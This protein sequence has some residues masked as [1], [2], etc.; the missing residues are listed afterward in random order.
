ME[1]KR[2]CTLVR[3]LLPQYDAG[4]CSDEVRTEIDGHLKECG[5]CDRAYADV[6]ASAKELEIERF[7][8][9][10]KKRKILG[11]ISLGLAAV[12]AVG[13]GF[14]LYKAFYRKTVYTSADTVGFFIQTGRDEGQT[15]RVEYKIVLESHP[16]N[17]GRS[18]ESFEMTVFSEDGEILLELDPAGDK[19]F[20]PSVFEVQDGFFL[21]V[22]VRPFESNYIDQKY[23][24][25]FYAENDLTGFLLSSP[26][27]YLLC[28][29]GADITE[30]A[31]QIRE[32]DDRFSASGWNITEDDWNGELLLDDH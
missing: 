22:S 28:C 17:P 11:G 9:K 20:S 21:P 18:M 2:I 32:Y 3:E 23:Y 24:G 25:T 6:H 29:P 7:I 13:G 15:V 1:D 10:Q 5:E 14:T 8:K 19:M 16:E 27:K 12:V 31:A 30:A 4:V 26:G